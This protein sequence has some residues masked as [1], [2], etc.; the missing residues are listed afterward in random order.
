MIYK[1]N[2]ILDNTYINKQIDIIYDYGNLKF[3][4]N[5][6]IKNLDDLINSPLITPLDIR[7][8]FIVK[9]IKN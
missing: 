8:S 2:F 7:S 1:F 9:I 4:S 3:T 5:Y 6:K